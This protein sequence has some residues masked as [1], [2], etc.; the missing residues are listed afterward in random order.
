MQALF[1]RYKRDVVKLTFTGSSDEHCSTEADMKAARAAVRE[2]HRLFAAGHARM[3]SLEES[4][5]S[6]SYRGRERK[7]RN[8]R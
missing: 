1:F 3:L 6:E 8:R 2:S 7:P 4:F 5:R